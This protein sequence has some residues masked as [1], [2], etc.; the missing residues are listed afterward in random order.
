MVTQPFRRER[1]AA[2][3]TA[4]LALSTLNGAVSASDTTITVADASDFP[5][6]GDFEIV[7]DDTEIA[8]VKSVSSNTFTLTTG[9]SGSH[10]DGS[11][12]A[13]IMSNASLERAIQHA[14]GKF[15]YPFNRI[16]DDDGSTLTAS[17]FTWFA[18]STSTCVDADDGGLRLTLPDELS[19]NIRGK[20]ITAPS[21]PWTVTAYIEMAEG[22]ARQDGAGQGS[23]GGIFARESSSNQL[24][25]LL[26]RGDVI[27]MWKMTDYQTFNADVNGTFLWNQSPGAWLQLADDGTYVTGSV[28]LNGYDFTEIWNESRTAFMAGGI[29]QIGFAGSSGVNITGANA[30]IAIKTWILE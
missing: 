23:Y 14:G 26:V 9:L 28:S 24:Y 20:Y 8:T 12:V 6:G 15:L 27:A 19:N 11:N 4:T 3:S 22:C 1:F 13:Q 29:D 16:L 2:T 17:D 7:I 21:T 18:Q 5:S 30:T 10:G 25:M